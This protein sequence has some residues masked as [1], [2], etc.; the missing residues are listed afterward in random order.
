MRFHRPLTAAAAALLCC[1]AL[2]GQA[3]DYHFDIDQTG[4]PVSWE[5]IFNLGDVTEQPPPIN[6]DGDLIMELDTPIAPFSSGNLHG[7]L[8]R[9]I[10]QTVTGVIDNPIPGFPP[11]GT[12]TVS[13]LQAE[14]HT[15][16][17][18]AINGNGDF[19]A[20][21]A[22]STTAGRVTLT[23]IFGSGSAT[24]AGLF[25]IWPSIPIQGNISQN[26][27]DIDLHLDLNITLPMITPS[28]TITG[29]ITLNGPIDAKAST[30]EANPMSVI[31]PY[32][33]PAGASTIIEVRD[34]T[35]TVLVFLAASTTG[36]GSFNAGSLGVILSLDSPFQVGNPLNATL[37]GNA[38]FQVFVPP[39][40]VGRSVWLQ[41]A[42][43]GDT[44]NVAG[45][46]VE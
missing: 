5:L 14:I 13:K 6:F 18:F 28:Q 15:I 40:L 16:A 3:T 36:L 37:A 33:L 11:L 41:A 19:V 2:P 4:P 12:F 29:S 32:P 17:P 30:T 38:F 26:G 24:I 45:T 23:G 7:S 44:S 39:T 20:D 22:M 25:Q 27:S 21:A 9:S 1:A 31:V 35:P 42:Q 10:P 43:I 46:W 34:A 8:I